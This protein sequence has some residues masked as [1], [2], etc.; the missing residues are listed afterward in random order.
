MQTMITRDPDD[1][2][3]SVRDASLDHVYDP[4]AIVAERF[5]L[6]VGLVR[7]MI[8]DTELFP[9]YR[10]WH[11][12]WK[13]RLREYN[14]QNY[15]RRIAQA[16]ACKIPKAVARYWKNVYAERLSTDTI[17]ALCYIAR[18]NSLTPAQF[19]EI[20]LK[21]PVPEFV[22]RKHSWWSK[23]EWLEKH[24][25]NSVRACTNLERQPLPRISLP[26]HQGPVVPSIVPHVT[27]PEEQTWFREIG[28]IVSAVL[29]EH[30]RDIMQLY[31]EQGLT[32]REIAELRGLPHGKVQNALHSAQRLL[33]CYLRQSLGD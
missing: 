5:S 12:H 9:S 7:E 8:R 13:N 29:P 27:S 4:E 15:K 17:Y 2:L 1:V 23:P 20:V 18:D 3:I 6:P 21:T 25:A 14:A 22:L 30:V 16:E 10:A 24:L 32:I 31:F 19:A 33:Y 11:E 28:A 26:S